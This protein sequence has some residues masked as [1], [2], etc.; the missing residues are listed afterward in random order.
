MGYRPGTVF[1][2]V[3]NQASIRAIGNPSSKSGQHIVQRVVEEFEK[4]RKDGFII[5]LHW[6]SAHM[7]LADN[8]LADKAAKEATGSI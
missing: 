3:D 6:V 7:G 8:E 1:L 5:E 4:L 2:C